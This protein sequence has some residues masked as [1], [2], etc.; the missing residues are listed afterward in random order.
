MAAQAR[1]SLQ[2]VTR[3]RYGTVRYGMVHTTFDHQKH[4]YIESRSVG[5]MTSLIHIRNKGNRSVGEFGKPRRCP[6]REPH[7]GRDQSPHSEGMFFM[8][9]TVIKAYVCTSAPACSR[10]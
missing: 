2:G 9:G 6:A 4:R 8:R 3:V 1:D 5:N 10:P 7:V